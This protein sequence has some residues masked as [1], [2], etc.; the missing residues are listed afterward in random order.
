[1]MEEGMGKNLAIIS[2]TEHG[3]R[4]NGQLS[5]LLSDRGYVCESCGMKK[6][7]GKYGL[8][9][10]TVSAKEWTG[11]MFASKDAILF[12]GAAGIAVRSIAP[13]LQ[14]KDKD[15]AV[16]VM[17]ERGVF[18]ISLLS[19]H[20][21]GANELAGVL[22]NLTGAIPVITTATDING[23]FAVDILAKKQNLWMSDLKAAKYVSAEVLD[24]NPVGLFCEL[25]VIGNIPEEL[26]VLKDGEAFDGSCGIVIS[27]NEEK[28]PFLHTLHLVPR[29]VTIG[30]GCRKGMG[31]EKIERAVLTALAGCH[32]SIHSV[33]LAASIDLK[34]EEQGILKFCRKF[35]IPFQTYTAEELLKISG[36]FSTSDFVKKTAGVDCVCERSAVLGSKNGMLVLKKQAANGVTIAAALREWSV[37]F[38]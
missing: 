11:Q 4:L 37:D 10:L 5:G 30:I 28:R 7:A 13:W 21:G 12:I 14:G 38:E 6:Y 18:V 16:V 20:L 3:S 32:L 29:I 19:G 35:G 36:E 22:A 15:P 31:A 24:E 9:P 23:R 25:P 1:M 33:E 26:T 8:Q 27:L 17:D 34:K 2:F